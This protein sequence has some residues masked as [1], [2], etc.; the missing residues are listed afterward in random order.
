MTFLPKLPQGTE[1][2]ECE[3]NPILYPPHTY[4]SGSAFLAN[5]TPPNKK[6]I[7]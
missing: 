3:S 7:L 1:N 4:L 6:P 2:S 5:L